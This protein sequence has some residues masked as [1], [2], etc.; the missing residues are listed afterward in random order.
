MKIIILHEIKKNKYFSNL[1]FKLLLN[2][3]FLKA[4]D[5]LTF[6]L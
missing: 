2:K 3:L 6:T 5:L 1:Y 4:V